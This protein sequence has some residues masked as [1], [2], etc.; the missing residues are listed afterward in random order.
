[1]RKA[2]EIANSPPNAKGSANR[3]STNWPSLAEPFILIIVREK[4]AASK[5]PEGVATKVIAKQPRN[6]K[7]RAIVPGA[8]Y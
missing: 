3:H 6:T 4:R 1:M 8:S 2:C 7:G 5:E